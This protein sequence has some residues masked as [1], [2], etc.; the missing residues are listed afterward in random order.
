MKI[1]ARV[2]GTLWEAGKFA[3]RSLSVALETAE[4]RGVHHLRVVF[5]RGDSVG[6]LMFDAATDEVI[7]TRQARPGPMLRALAHGA[8]L[9]W[10]DAAAALVVEP[11]AG[12]MD[13][14]GEAPELCA[15]REAEEEAPGC[16]ILS[17][18]KIAAYWPSPGGCSE[19]I[20][21]FCAVVDSSQA[22]ER[23][24]LAEHGEEIEVLR[25]PAGEAIAMARDGRIDTA[26]A[27]I[28]LEWLA[29]RRGQATA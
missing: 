7:L 11:V 28:A 16:R 3:L 26:M 22:Q 14:A 13:V 18:E 5:D 17:V 6:L 25:L 10:D 8:S 4:G 29:R 15:R 1:R 24:G 27:I 20:H 19:R 2:L 23:G 12:S 9:E 21:L